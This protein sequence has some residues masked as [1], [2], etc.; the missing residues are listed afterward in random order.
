VLDRS[1]GQ[2]H[3][4]SEGKFAECSQQQLSRSPFC[5]LQVSVHAADVKRVL[6]AYSLDVPAKDK[7]DLKPEPIIVRLRKVTVLPYLV[8]DRSPFA[9]LEALVMTVYEKEFT[10]WGKDFRIGF[11]ARNSRVRY[12]RLGSRP[13]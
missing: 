3:A 13:V 10:V 5:H 9:R 1:I 4:E 12:F 8:Q 6:R 2:G 11:Q 7:D